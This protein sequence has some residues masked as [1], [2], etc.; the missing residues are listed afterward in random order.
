[1]IPPGDG[2]RILIGG[3]SFYFNGNHI[4]RSEGHYI[5]LGAY[6]N[7][8]ADTLDFTGNYWGTVEADTI[9]EWI[10][11]GR[12]DPDIYGIVE[13][14]PFSPVPVSTEKKSMGDVKHMFR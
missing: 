11:D 9:S 12:D 2:E 3:T 14:E 1:M 8:P 4:F 7:P 10:W 6:V 13:Y 5:K